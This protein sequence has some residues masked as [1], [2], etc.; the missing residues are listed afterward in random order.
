MAASILV[1][2]GSSRG[3][4]PQLSSRTNVLGAAI[5]SKKGL[6]AASVVRIVE[7]LTHWY[8][9]EEPEG[10]SPQDIIDEI[11][12]LLSRYLRVQ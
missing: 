2:P 5:R 6:L 3:K 11:T 10:V 1:A 8:V 7:S 12:T 4:C 9:L